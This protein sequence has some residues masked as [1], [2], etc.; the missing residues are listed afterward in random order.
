MRLIA[1][2]FC[3]ALLTTHILLKNVEQYCIVYMFPSNLICW[4]SAL[5]HSKYE[6]NI[7]FLQNARYMAH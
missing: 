1:I 7:V 6:L 4:I 5:S 3:T 2:N